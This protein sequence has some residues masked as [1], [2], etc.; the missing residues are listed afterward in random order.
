MNAAREQEKVVIAYYYDDA[1]GGFE[2]YAHLWDDPMIGRFVGDLAVAIAID[3]GSEEGA[4]FHEHVR[5]R[6][7]SESI[8]PGIYFFSYA[9][10]SL[11]ALH[12][13]LAGLEGVGRVMMMLGMA[14]YAS[15]ESKG[16]RPYRTRWH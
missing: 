13:D 10:R 15:G 8:A 7:E 14:E 11:G 16:R 12:G 3:A 2:A 4:A 1:T 9:G 5:R 6:L